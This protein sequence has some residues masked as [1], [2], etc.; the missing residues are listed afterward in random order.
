MYSSVAFAVSARKFGSVAWR[1]HAFFDSRRERKAETV[2]AYDF[3]KL[4][5]FYPWH[6][7]TT[8]LLLCTRSDSRFGS[9]LACL[10]LIRDFLVCLSGTILLFSDYELTV[11][12]KTVEYF[13]SA[14]ASAAGFLSS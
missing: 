9:I 2:Q 5:A 8:L 4:P 14:T 11:S 13:L 12:A 1:W 7:A 10:R 6:K 3:L